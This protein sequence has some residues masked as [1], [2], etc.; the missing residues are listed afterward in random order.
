IFRIAA[1]YSGVVPQ[2]PPTIEAPLINHER[3]CAQYS[4]ISTV[5]ASFH[6]VI[7]SGTLLLAYAPNGSAVV[8]ERTLIA[9]VV[10]YGEA[11]LRN[12]ASGESADN[13]FTAS[14]RSSPLS[15]LPFFP[16]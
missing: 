11:Q 10:S 7:S 3:T 4:P 6:P 13:S 12:N 5:C 14:V 16:Q 15:N 9:S 1:I 8:C 2:Q